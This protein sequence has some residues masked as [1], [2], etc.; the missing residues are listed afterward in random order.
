MDINFRGTLFSPVYIAT[1]WINYPWR[2]SGPHWPLGMD[3]NS[4]MSNSVQPHR[5]TVARQAPLSMGFPRQEHWSGL[6]FPS[7]GD[8]SNP[9]I[10]L[11][12]PSS[13]ALAGGFLTRYHHLGSH[14]L[15]LTILSLNSWEVGLWLCKLHSLPLTQ[16][17][18]WEVGL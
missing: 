9:R 2:D 18:G 17:L 10:K 15:P 4:V 1:K 12:S 3:A 6:P 11:T 16:S 7:P 14:S 8:L 13:P 5:W